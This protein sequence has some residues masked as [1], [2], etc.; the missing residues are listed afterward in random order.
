MQFKSMLACG[1]LIAT[2][3]LSGCSENPN[4]FPGEGITNS[5][6]DYIPSSAVRVAESVGSAT[7]TSDSQGTAYI[8]DLTRLDQTTEKTAVPHVLT[9][10]LLLKGQ[11]IIIDG[12]DQTVKVSGQLNVTPLQ[13]KITALKPDATYQIYFDKKSH[14]KF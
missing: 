12:S 10:Q 11:T 14:Y 3:A 13:Y 5:Y 9:S 2:G 8:V 7:Y 1:M 4:P 6:R